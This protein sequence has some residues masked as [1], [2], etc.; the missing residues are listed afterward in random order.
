MRLVVFTGPTLPAVEVRRVL[1]DDVAVLPPAAQGDVWRAVKNGAEAIGLI[2]GAFDQVDA[3]AHKEILAAMTAGVHVVGAAS[4]G[5]LRAAELHAFGMEGTGAIFARYLAGAIEDDDEVAV[6]HAPADLDFRPLS[7]AMVNIRATLA[8]AVAAGV[9]DEALHDA[10]I[11][12]AKSRFYAER[13]WPVLY[14][15]VRE[16]GAPAPILDG[17]ITFV[18]SHRVDQKRLDALAL[19]DRL[20]ALRAHPPGRKIVAYTFSHT[21][22]W[23]ALRRRVTDGFALPRVSS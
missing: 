3:V 5:A 8:A 13:A 7:E 14:A 6:L 22:A 9:L 21:D 12:E 2:D 4:M 18:E 19:L 23:E 20:A 1:G 11:E 17:L 16:S 15:R 10:L